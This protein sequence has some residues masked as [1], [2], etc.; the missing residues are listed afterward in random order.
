MLNGLATGLA[1]AQEAT[2]AAEAGPHT[3]TPVAE[4]IFELFGVLPVTNAVFTAWLV[5]VVLVLFAFF[6][7]RNLK[8]LPSGVQNFWELVVELWIGVVDQSMGKRG[9]RFVPLLA[10]SFLF[11]LFSNWI[12][13][14]PIV[15]NVLITNP[16]GQTV[17]LFRSANSDLN[18]TAAMA[19]IVILLSEVLE[20]R[21]L[22][23]G[24]YFKGLLIPN[25]LR[26]LEIV[27]RPLSLGFRL[28]G[29]IFAGEVLVATMLGLAPFAL[30]PFLGLEVF[31]GLIQALIFSMLAM[32]FIT[33]ATAHEHGHEEHLEDTGHDGHADLVASPVHDNAPAIAHGAAH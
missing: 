30:F 19:V 14:L 2:H 21:A 8:M 28:F 10:T 15:G 4:T 26:W 17:P 22:G 6:S 27:T 18:L 7:T 31:V 24:G 9:R 29:N 32:T 13:I 1:F 5:I 25:F 23:P 20:F 12:G 11:I 33:I 16:E 3:P